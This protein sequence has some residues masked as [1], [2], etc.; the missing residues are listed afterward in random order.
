MQHQFGSLEPE[1]LCSRNW[2]G[3]REKSGLLGLIEGKDS[4]GLGPRDERIRVVGSKYGGDSEVKI[5]TKPTDFQPIRQKKI[6]ETEV[7]EQRN[8]LGVPPTH[9][10]R[11]GTGLVNRL[12]R[13]FN[14]Q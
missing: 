13:Q 10:G 4:E 6:Y 5:K 14:N 8:P 12:K 2:D 7:H 3:G 1:N 11:E 9:L